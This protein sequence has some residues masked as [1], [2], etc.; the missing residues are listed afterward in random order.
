MTV[1]YEW[2]VEEVQDYIDESGDEQT[3]IIEHWFQMS[4]EDC[5]KHISR[6]PA[7]SGNRYDIVL[8]RDDDDGRS[9]AYME[10]GKLP[11]YAEN[12]FGED[13]GKIPK[14]YHAEVA[15]YKA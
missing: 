14:K 1:Y 11:E 5:I 7:P 3:E 12:A 9:W 13:C 2:D 8:V 6:R 4:Y 10:G 15:R